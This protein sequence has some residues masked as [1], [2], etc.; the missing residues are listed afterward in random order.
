MGG[1]KEKKEKKEKKVKK[2][3]KE[4]K[5]KN[6]Q[7]ES[8]P[9]SQAGD[10]P[11]KAESALDQRKLF[12]EGQKNLTPPVADATRAFYESLLSENPESKIAIK[13]CVEYGILALEDHKK[14]LAKFNRLKDK[15]A[16]DARVL[17]KKSLEKA[18]RKDV[19][20][21]RESIEDRGEEVR[22]K[23]E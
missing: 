18:S 13:Y 19:K 5:E 22:E 17:I 3:K 14:I 11:R 10:N 6:N 20:R 4:K 9:W 16:Y 23:K 2:E 21:Y 12:K 7:A 1:S 15:G 8:T